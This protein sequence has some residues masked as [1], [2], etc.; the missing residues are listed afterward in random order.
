MVV[1]VFQKKLLHSL[2][3]SIPSIF[4][5]RANVIQDIT[6]VCIEVFQKNDFICFQIR[7]RLSFDLADFK[8]SNLLSS[9]GMYSFLLL[10]HE[11]VAV[12]SDLDLECERVADADDDN[13]EDVECLGFCAAVPYS[14]CTIL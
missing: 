2:L 4:I 9:L 13:D 6:P 10:M 8:T 5:H 11:A 3:Y 14:F 7:K 1:I 12:V